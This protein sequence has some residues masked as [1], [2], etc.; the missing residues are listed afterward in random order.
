MYDLK[1]HSK[2]F[3]AVPELKHAPWIPGRQYIYMRF[4]DFFHLL[5]QDLHR[6]L[7]LRNVINP[8]A[9][10]ALIR[11]LDLDK[12]D[13]RNRFQQFSGLRANSLAMNEVAW[14]VISDTPFQRS[15]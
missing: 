14:I 13:S 15:F 2:F 1:I 5:V 8:R 3:S 9:A 4:L 12:L 11:A 6:Q 10:T 7:I